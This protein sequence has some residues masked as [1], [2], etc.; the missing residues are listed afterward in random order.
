MDANASKSQLLRAAACLLLTLLFASVMHALDA[1]AIVRMDAMS[2]VDYAAYQR[3][4]HQHS[5]LYIYVVLLIF[6]GVYLGAVEVVAGL[7]GFVLPGK[8]GR[9]PGSVQADG[10]RSQA[11]TSN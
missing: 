5:Y 6:G 10:N 7:L 9:T 8:P 2:P 1:R 4:V 11:G 3:H